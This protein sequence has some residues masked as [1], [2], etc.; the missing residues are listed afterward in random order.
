MEP[1][2][3]ENIS[4]CKEYGGTGLGLSISKSLLELMDSKLE[5]ISEKHK[6]STFFF[7]FTSELSHL[8]ISG[9]SVIK[10]SSTTPLIKRCS[11]SQQS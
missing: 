11:M 7:S 3:Q 4:T 8:L 1:F 9:T 5:V 10:V 6:G 2:S